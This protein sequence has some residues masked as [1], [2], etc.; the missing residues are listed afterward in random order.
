MLSTLEVISGISNDCADMSDKKVLLQVRIDSELKKK[1]AI[2]AIT[3]ETNAS[4]LVEAILEREFG[5]RNS[6]VKP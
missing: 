5:D 1:I 4:A 2:A 6:E 3:Q